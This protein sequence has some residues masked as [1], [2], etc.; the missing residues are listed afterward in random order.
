M[1]LSFTLIYLVDHGDNSILQIIPYTN[2]LKINTYFFTV[3]MHIRSAKNLTV[4]PT[5]LP[6]FNKLRA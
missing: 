4:I 6:K 3:L 2:I 5:I 1:F